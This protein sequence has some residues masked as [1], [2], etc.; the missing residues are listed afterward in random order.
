[1]CDSL[2]VPSEQR[3]SDVTQTWLNATRKQI[4]EFEAANPPPQSL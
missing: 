3:A 1:M 2:A 4:N